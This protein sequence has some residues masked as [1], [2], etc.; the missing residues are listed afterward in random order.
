MTQVINCDSAAFWG[1]EEKDVAQDITNEFYPP[2]WNGTGDGNDYAGSVIFQEFDWF[3]F[4]L[5]FF[6]H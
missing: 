5:V 6:F 1:Q 3:A 4:F 2:K